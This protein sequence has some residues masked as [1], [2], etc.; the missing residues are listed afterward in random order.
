MILERKKKP[1]GFSVRFR[2]N[3]KEDCSIVV[4]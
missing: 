1:Q 4:K 3:G 2:V